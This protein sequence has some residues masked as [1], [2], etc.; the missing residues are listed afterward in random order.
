MPNAAQTKTRV[1]LARSRIVNF[2]QRTAATRPKRAYLPWR[3]NAAPPGR[4]A[5]DALGRKITLRPA[6]AG[7][8]TQTSPPDASS[9]AAYKKNKHQHIIFSFLSVKGKRT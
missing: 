9:R 6:D 8:R 2:P 7:R 1:D 3:K 5:L 4:D